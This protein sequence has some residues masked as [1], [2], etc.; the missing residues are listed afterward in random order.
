MEPQGSAEHTLRNTGLE[1]LQNILDKVT[2][3]SEQFGLSIN[4]A[5]TNMMI[6]S[7]KEFH[8]INLK[9]NNWKSTQI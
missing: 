5:K 1:D 9:I 3:V 8:N 7:R 6:I 4:I 2:E